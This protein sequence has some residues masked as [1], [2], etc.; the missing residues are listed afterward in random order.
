MAFDVYKIG[1]RHYQAFDMGANIPLGPLHKTR[2]DAWDW[3]WDHKAE[4]LRDKLYG[5]NTA[6]R[7]ELQGIDVRPGSGD[8]EGK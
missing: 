1:S 5:Q 4:L 8:G 6:T 7:T 3:V 2:Q